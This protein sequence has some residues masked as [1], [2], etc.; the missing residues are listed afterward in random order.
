MRSDEVQVLWSNW[1]NRKCTK[2]SILNIDIYFFVNIP[3]ELGAVYMCKHR[4]CRK[5]ADGAQ[6]L[7]WFDAYF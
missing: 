7:K 3:V 1:I 6:A 4:V 2:R 5:A